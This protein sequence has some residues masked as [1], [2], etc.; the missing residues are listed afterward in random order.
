MVI[1]RRQTYLDEA[2]DE[3]RIC[4]GAVLYPGTRLVRARTFGAPGPK[5]GIGGPWGHENTMTGENTD[6]ASGYLKEAVMLRNARVGSN[7]HVRVGTVLEEEPS[8]AHAV[9]LKHAVLM[10]F[11]T[12]G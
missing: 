3:S 10:S 11:V 6:V 7:A 8:T 5:V 4:R 2:V 1:D 9:G 12:M